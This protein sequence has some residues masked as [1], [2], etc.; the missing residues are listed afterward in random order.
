M[1]DFINKITHSNIS[2]TLRHD[3]CTG[4]GICQSACPANAISIIVKQGRFIPQVDETKCNNDK[5][6][7][8]CSDVCPGLGMDLHRIA[9][10]SF[11]DAEI[12][13]DRLVG[14]YLK[15]FTGHSNDYDIRYHCASGG[16][17]SQFLIFLLEKNYIDG[18][19]VTAF[20]PENEL[21]VRS[22]IAHNR[23]EVLRARSS[24]YAPVSLHG[25]AQAIKQ[26]SG[27]RYVIVGLPCHIQGF[28]KLAEIDRKLREKVAGYFAI[29][30]SSG[31]TFYLTEHIFKEHG[32]CK[33][34]LTYFAYRDEG[35]LGS[36]VARQR[37]GIRVRSNSETTLYDKDEVYKERFQSYYHPLRS[38]FIPRR[39]LFC[40]DHYGELG[41]VCFGDIHIEPY[42][43]DTIGVNSLIVR[44]REWLE[45]LM[46]AK[47]EGYITLDEIPV[48]TL[49]RSQM[50][51]YKKKGRNARFIALNK[52][53]GRKVP[54]YDE[55][56][57]KHTGMKTALDYTQNRI[58]QFLGGH[59]GLWWLVKIIR[60]TIFKR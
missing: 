49:N 56:L 16:M 43:Q 60:D 8:R 4:C 32:I 31:R 55:A 1:K 13:T 7:H 28:R 58:Q 23:E 10:E 20:D 27:T 44:Q 40:I 5:G 29:Y 24:K 34:D 11:T 41:D 39:C 36:L 35:C 33:E 38:F 47:G 15:C 17:V 26:E 12:K 46:E 53:L 9:E 14:R 50:M 48:E 2:Y 57:P 3:L 6:C 25:M 30:C 45:R 19:V 52:M 59:K 37:R 54:V 18:A 42:K 21:L 51:A 22:Y